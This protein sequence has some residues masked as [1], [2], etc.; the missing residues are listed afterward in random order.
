M[1]ELSVQGADGVRRV[2]PLASE[3]VSIGRSRDND[4][5]LPDQWL[6]RAHA[7][8]QVRD[9]GCYV[10]DLG[11]KNGTLL[12]G[13][14][15]EREER[16]QAGDV[17]TLGE[18]LVTFVEEEAG[19]LDEAEPVGTQIFSAVELSA[20]AQRP[21]TGP[22]EL[23]RQNRVLG[24]LSRAAS[25]LIRH[26]P[27]GELFETIIGLM[28]EAVP[29]ERAAILLLEDERPVVKASRSRRG[30]QIQTIS[31]SIA[32]SVLENRN[33]LLVPNILEDASLKSQ[34]SILS[35]G[36]RLGAVC[37]IDV[38]PRMDVDHIGSAVL[39]MANLPLESNVLFM[40]IKATEM[41]YEGRG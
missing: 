37:A 13:A 19:A 3:R 11:S 7:E 15:L 14:R 29:A 33:A 30:E 28:L 9:D 38:Q 8:I 24:I 6:S 25:H 27:L 18:H 4:L 5:F 34:D 12:N 21:P 2:V 22:E 20:V 10:V 32:R 17:I 31:R 35:T 23:A 1:P 16:L 40:T 26:Q 36:V 39:Y 41:P